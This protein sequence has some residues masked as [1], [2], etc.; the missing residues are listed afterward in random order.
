MSSLEMLPSVKMLQ[1]MQ[2]HGMARAP[3]NNQAVLPRVHSPKERL[4]FFNYKL[5]KLLQ[6]GN[7]ASMGRAAACQHLLR[8]RMRARWMP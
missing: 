8:C 1:A 5:H 2:L 6:L 3:A 7:M 4:Q